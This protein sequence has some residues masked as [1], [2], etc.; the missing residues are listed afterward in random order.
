MYVCIFIYIYIVI[1]VKMFDIS[2]KVS[3]LL[4]KVNYFLNFPS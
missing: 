2:T 3:I 4:V 1:G